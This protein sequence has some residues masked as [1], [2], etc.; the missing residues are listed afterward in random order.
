MK[1]HSLMIL[2][3]ALMTISIGFALARKQPKIL[4]RAGQPLL[5]ATLNQDGAQALAKKSGCFECHS[6][7]KD[8]TGPSYRN[9][10]ERYK[11]DNTARAKLV[12]TVKRGGKGKWMKISQGMPMPPY[13]PRLS[14]A[15]IKRL[16]DW[17]LSLKDNENK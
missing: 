9:V 4:A 5:N 1:Q 14:D 17:V 13:S 3:I 6:I 7:D 11:D 8:E 15:E 12:E 2:A 16:V 10:A